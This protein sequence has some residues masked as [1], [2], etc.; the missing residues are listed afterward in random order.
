[1]HRWG[2]RSIMTV[3]LT[4]PK[5]R[6]HAADMDRIFVTVT[7]PRAGPGRSPYASDGPLLVRIARHTARI[8]AATQYLSTH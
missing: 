7:S 6:I 4:G 5:T 3:T 1:M 8:C 2:I